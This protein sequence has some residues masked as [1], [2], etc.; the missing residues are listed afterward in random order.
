MNES[1]SKDVASP[2]RKRIKTDD[3]KES[4]GDGSSVVADT[5]TNPKEQKQVEGS[6]TPIPESKKKRA[7]RP[8][9]RCNSAQAKG[10][11]AQH[12]QPTTQQHET[13]EDRSLLVTKPAPL[14]KERPG[15]SPC[16]PSSSA[17]LNV[18]EIEWDKLK[19]SQ[20]SPS[21][22][23][24]SKSASTV[25]HHAASE[26]VDA[27]SPTHER[28]IHELEVKEHELEAERLEAEGAELIRKG[29]EKQALAEHHRRQARVH[30]DQALA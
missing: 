13:R 19:S 12:R 23:D 11:H 30:K 17:G 6:I 3:A 28:T 26:N 16:A 15:P 22:E 24:T 2:P 5:A 21:T 25:T 9:A 1:G 10:Q 4:K 14:T 27:T 7:R 29:C 8:A 18:P 20:A